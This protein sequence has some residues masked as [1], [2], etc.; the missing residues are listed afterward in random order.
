MYQLD[1]RSAYLNAPISEEVYLEQP[2]GFVVDNGNK[3]LYCK[4]EK[5]LYGLKQVGKEWNKTLVNWFLSHGFTQSK[6]DTCL[7]FLVRF[8]SRLVVVVWVDDVLYFCSDSALSS[9][10]KSEFQK[11]FAIEDK[12][13]MS[14]F[15][16]SSQSIFIYCR[17]SFERS[18]A[19]MQSCVA[20]RRGQL[21]SLKGGLCCR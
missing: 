15:L 17:C 4:L 13:S 19:G 6:F 18:Q 10:F 9:W 12:G 14:W 11:S 7:F 20:A 5:C 3:P 21:A 16:G 2:E 8:L 1:V